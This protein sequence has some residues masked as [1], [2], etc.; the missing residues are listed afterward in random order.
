MSQAGAFLFDR[1]A[2]AAD[3]SGWR[4]APRRFDVAGAELGNDAGIIGAAAV[5]WDAIGLDVAG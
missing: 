3:R 2:A 1:V 4:L 5:A